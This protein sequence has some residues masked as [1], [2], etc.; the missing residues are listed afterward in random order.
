MLPRD[1]WLLTRKRRPNTVCRSFEGNHCAWDTRYKSSI[2]QRIP[3]FYPSPR[4]LPHGVRQLT[5]SGKRGKWRLRE[6]TTT[7]N[8][9]TTTYTTCHRTRRTKCGLRKLSK[10]LSTGV[11]GCGFPDFW[12]VACCRAALPPDERERQ[13][14]GWPR[15]S[16]TNSEAPPPEKTL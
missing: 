9:H 12:R 8:K 5:L 14:L 10:V 11:A 7:R 1:D 15:P 13:G 6:R 4:C 3:F 16:W 2:C